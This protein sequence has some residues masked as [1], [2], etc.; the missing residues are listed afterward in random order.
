MTKWHQKSSSLACSNR[1]TAGRRF[2]GGLKDNRQIQG[3]GS[4]PSHN[5]TRNFKYSANF[6]ELSCGDGNTCRLH[7]IVNQLIADE[8]I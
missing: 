3:W 6:Q 1:V 5:L 7:N 2:T 4:G 8:Q